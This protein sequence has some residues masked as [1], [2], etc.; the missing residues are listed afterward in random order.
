MEPARDHLSRAVAIKRITFGPDSSELV[1]TLANLAFVARQAGDVAQAH[2]LAGEDA[3]IARA[4][5]PETHPVRR[6]VDETLTSD[7]SKAH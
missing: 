4:S 6:T 2:H 1:A 7:L 3:R 5:L